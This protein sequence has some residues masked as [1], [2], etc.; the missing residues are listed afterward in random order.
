[1]DWGAVV[2][3]RLRG[4]RTRNLQ[5]DGLTSIFPHM[6][7]YHRGGGG[8]EVL[9]GLERSHLKWLKHN[10]AFNKFVQWRCVTSDTLTDSISL[11]KQKGFGIVEGMNWFGGLI[12]VCLAKVMGLLR[13]V[14]HM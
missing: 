1:M 5:T 10:E 6:P 14:L 12:W 11:Q 4:F 7:S 2:G 3:H 9:V 13:W 8:I